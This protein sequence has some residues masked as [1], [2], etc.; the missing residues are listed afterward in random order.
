MA[1]G[2][3]PDAIPVTAAQPHGKP[4][5]PWELRF[6]RFVDEGGE[7]GAHR[8]SRGAGITIAHTDTGYTLHP[9]LMHGNNV[10]TL[11]A[12]TFAFPAPSFPTQLARQFTSAGTLRTVPFTDNGLDPL[13]GLFPSH[14]TATASL[15]M[16]AEGAPPSTTTPPYPSRTAQTAQEFDEMPIVGT[17]PDAEYLPIRVTDSVIVDPIVANNLA[18]AIEHV[19]ELAQNDDSIGVISI[20][21]G[22]PGGRHLNSY[23]ALTRAIDRATQ[24]GVVVCAAAA[25]SGVPLSDFFEAW[26]QVAEALAGPGPQGTPAQQE[27]ARVARVLGMVERF[28]RLQ[29]GTP[30]TIRALCEAVV[31]QARG[32]SPARSD[33][34][35][36]G[37][38][39]YVEAAVQTEV[40][41]FRA[42]AGPAYPGSDLNTICCAGCDYLGN[43]MHDGF[44]GAEVDITAPAAN[45]YSAKAARNDQ[46]D[47]DYYVQRSAGTSYATAI[48]AG[49]CA[50][51]QAH[52]GRAALIAKFG[53]PLILH[54]FR[55][56]LRESAARQTVTGAQVP[57][58]SARRGFGMLDAAALLR[59]ALPAG[60]RELIDA[61][62]GADM[63]GDATR[64]VL[65]HRAK[66][67]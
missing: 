60:P 53:R 36:D 18:I 3:A 16:S 63:I 42:L 46:G 55:W 64:A 13:D 2:F 34:Q 66:L 24:A 61:L 10:R 48:T 37:Y 12:R 7:A 62:R 11:E 45:T 17:A 57:W 29:L 31:T 1:V 9:E 52:H 25:Q 19:A 32:A 33:K 30:Q 15:F 8:L 23:T 50:L 28:C 4:D 38:L 58:D 35:I 47:I 26:A 41:V 51:W 40:N 14:G 49:A 21:L 5:E 43:R 22:W 65:M 6:S 39:R 44:Y 20:S 54:A 67:N 56:A 59:Q 27:A